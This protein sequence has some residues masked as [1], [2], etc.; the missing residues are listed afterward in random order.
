MS[1]KEEIIDLIEK[2]VLESKSKELFRKP[3]VG[4]SSASNPLYEK[5]KVIVGPHHV[6]PKDILPNA[7]SV[8]SFFIPFSEMV[9]QSNSK[10]TVVSREWGKSYIEANILL[11]EISD[12]LIE[13]LKNKN[14]DSAT[15]RA[16]HTYDEETLI[17]TWSHRSAACIAKL[18]KF[19]V[20]RMLITKE[21][22]AGRFG[23]VIIS[24]NIPETEEDA[25]EYCLYN[26]NESCL[27]CI[28]SCPQNALRVDGFDKFKC[29]DQ[30]L[31]NAEE[32]K[33]IGLCDVCGKCVVSCPYAV[34]KS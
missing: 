34:I 27:K 8:I 29:H 16:T 31:K 22:Y 23:T 13:Y 20:N 17:S 26:K 32:L 2:S 14:I 3:I 30:L 25:K 7:Q 4:F 19:G 9:V 1:L 15:I 6:H 18:G 11:N 33:D 21:G 10:D 5:L 28:N 12:N 24:A